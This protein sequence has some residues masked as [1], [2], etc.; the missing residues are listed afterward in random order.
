VGISAGRWHFRT[1]EVLRK[2]RSEDFRRELRLLAMKVS[3]LPR[4]DG[5]CFEFEA[6]L[7]PCLNKNL[8][9]GHRLGKHGVGQKRLAGGEQKEEVKCEFI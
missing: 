7:D 2:T 5:S 6:S 3:I 4:F 9:E 1:L 8:G